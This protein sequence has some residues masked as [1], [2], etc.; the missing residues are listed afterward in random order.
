MSNNKVEKQR[1]THAK[2]TYAKKR[3]IK[4][5]KQSWL[6]IYAERARIETPRVSSL[7]TLE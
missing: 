7:S 6:Q 3:L 5:R 1:S 4:L 2:V